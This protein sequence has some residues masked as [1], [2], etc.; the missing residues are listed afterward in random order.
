M[1]EIRKGRSVEPVL[2]IS[3]QPVTRQDLLM[4]LAANRAERVL[5]MRGGDQV[6]F[7]FVA[8]AIDIGHGAGADRMGMVT[9]GAK[10]GL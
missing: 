5:F 7:G 9:P 10:S 6:D 3:R 1:L 8:G 2:L 4:R